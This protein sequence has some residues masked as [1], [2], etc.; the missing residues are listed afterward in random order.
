MRARCLN[1]NDTAYPHYGGRGIS[2]CERWSRFENFFADMGQCPPKGELERINNE[3]NYEPGNC[4]WATR[5]EQLRNTR[6][7]TSIEYG[8]R[9]WCRTDLAAHLGI[10]PDTLKRRIASG[11]PQESWA[12]M[13]SPGGWRSRRERGDKAAFA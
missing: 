2:I 3:G 5:A 7:T 12:V 9:K 13:P 8:G 1:P 10:R 4:R 11:W 6:R